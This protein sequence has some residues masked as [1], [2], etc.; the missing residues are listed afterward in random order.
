MIDSGLDVWEI[1]D[2]LRSYGDDQA[3]LL[4]EHPRLTERCLRTIRSEGGQ[5]ALAHAPERAFEAPEA[6]EVRGHMTHDGM[7]PAP[8]GYSGYS[9]GNLPCGRGPLQPGG[10]AVPGYEPHLG[11]ATE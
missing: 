3:R 9:M 11:I 6:I 10:R 7:T 1:I 4:E 5:G 8:S 2:L